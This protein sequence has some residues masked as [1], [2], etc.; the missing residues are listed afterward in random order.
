MHCAPKEPTARKDM[1][2][3]SKLVEIISLTLLQR[4]EDIPAVLVPKRQ[5]FAVT[6]RLA[7]LKLSLL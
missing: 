5:N 3:F 2:R 1:K 7:L 6:V 4:K